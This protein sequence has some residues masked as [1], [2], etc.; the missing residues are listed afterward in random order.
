[1]AETAKTPGSAKAV[2]I[3]KRWKTDEKFKMTI[4]RK[5]TGKKP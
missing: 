4:L 3:K 5:P 2:P 1:M